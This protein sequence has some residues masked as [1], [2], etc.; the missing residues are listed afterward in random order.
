MGAIS[1]TIK[2]VGSNILKDS[3]NF[4][5]EI[6]FKVAGGKYKNSISGSTRDGLEMFDNY[7]NSLGLN[8]NDVKVVDASGVS[9]YNLLNANWM[10]SALSK[11]SNTN[12]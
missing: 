3:D 10:T 12:K 6:V 2:E 8:L 9:R 11:I 5:S 1:H 4:S 7:F